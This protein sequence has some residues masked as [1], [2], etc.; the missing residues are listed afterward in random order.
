MSLKEVQL[1]MSQMN[2]L[3]RERVFNDKHA[4]ELKEKEK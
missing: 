1:D 4:Q 3:E 2:H